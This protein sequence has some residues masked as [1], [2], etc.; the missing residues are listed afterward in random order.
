MQDFSVFIRAV[1]YNCDVLFCAAFCKVGGLSIF[2]EGAV[3]MRFSYLAK[4]RT[5]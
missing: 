3:V 4:N 1:L 5:I 2:W